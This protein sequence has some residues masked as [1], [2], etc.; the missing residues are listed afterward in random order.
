LKLRSFTGTGIFSWIEKSG[1][2]S[3]SS[4][5]IDSDRIQISSVAKYVLALCLYIDSNYANKIIGTGTF[6]IV[7][8]LLPVADSWKGNTKSFVPNFPSFF[9]FILIR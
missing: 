4:Q 3:G 7:L 1:H 9:I 8:L 6:G 5:K 2:K